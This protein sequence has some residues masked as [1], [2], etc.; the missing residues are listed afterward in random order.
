MG[1]GGVGFVHTQEGD[2]KG[3]KRIVLP[4]SHEKDTHRHTFRMPP[5]MGVRWRI[6]NECFE[7][8][9]PRSGLLSTVI[10]HLSTVLRSPSYMGEKC[11]PPTYRHHPGQKLSGL[12]IPVNQKLPLD[13]KEKLVYYLV[14]HSSN[15]GDYLTRQPSKQVDIKSLKV[16]NRRLSMAAG[17]YG[18]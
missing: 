5:Y 2:K 17:L 16:Q 4:K 13:M 18:G 1:V 14:R 6:L 15:K 11:I 3:E 10:Q 7:G 9:F 12:Q 8:V